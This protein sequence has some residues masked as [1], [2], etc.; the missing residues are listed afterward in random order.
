MAECNSESNVEKIKKIA[1]RLSL[2][3][4]KVTITDKTESQFGMIKFSI[5]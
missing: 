2:N 4:A 5:S 3:N 1:S